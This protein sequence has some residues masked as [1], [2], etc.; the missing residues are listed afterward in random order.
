M[1]S[2]LLIGGIAAGVGIAGKL[3]SGGSGGKNR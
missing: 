3:I 2:L 1:S